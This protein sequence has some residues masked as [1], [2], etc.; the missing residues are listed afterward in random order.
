MCHGLRL[1]LLHLLHLFGVSGFHLLGLRLMLLLHLLYPLLVSM[2]LHG[3]L[4]VF[5]L[6]LCQLLVL[7]LLLLI[8][9][10]LLLLVL[11]IELGVP[12]VRRRKLL[13]R[14]HLACVRWH[15][16]P[17]VDRRMIRRTCLLGGYDSAATEV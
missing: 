3:L 5:L 14:L 16:R 2:L 11:L 9:L 6:L 8:K 12:G 7:R 10:P 13:M 15:V 1:P 4:V 17:S